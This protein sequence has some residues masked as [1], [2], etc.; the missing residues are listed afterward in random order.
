MGKMGREPYA[1][2]PTVSPRALVEVIDYLL[3]T[4]HSHGGG[5]RAGEN[6]PVSLPTGIQIEVIDQ[7]LE[8]RLLGA[9]ELRGED[10]SPA[11]QFHAVHAYVRRVWRD[12]ESIPDDLYRWDSEGRLYP[13][14]QLSRLVRDNA[15]STEFAVRRLRRADG[16]ECLVPFSGFDSHLAYRLHP[17][18]RGWLDE[19]EARELGQLL[20]AYWS[21]LPLP[22]RVGRALRRADLVTRERYLEDALPIVVGGIEALVK[23]GRR[24][25]TGQFACRGSR[26]AAEFGIDLSEARVREIYNDRSALVHGADVDL[27][28]P[29]ALDEFG[30]GFIA[31]QETLRCA[32]RRAIEDREFAAIFEDD[33]RISLRWSA[34]GS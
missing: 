2:G 13:C 12:G 18:E 16:S 20:E 24:A 26:L 6:G 7:A 32:V 1:A 34:A 29:Q 19:D 27:S 4:A 10:W 11:R 8:Q 31:L 14:V 22:A 30:E 33:D 9:C 28:E 3:V 25:L 21:A 23:I 5:M 15:T 17:E